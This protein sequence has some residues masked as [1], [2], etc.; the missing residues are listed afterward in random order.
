MQRAGDR[1][2]TDR[3]SLALAEAMGWRLVFLVGDPAYYARYGFAVAPANIVMPDESPSRLQYRTLAGASL[4]PGG[5]ILLRH[6]AAMRHRPSSDLQAQRTLFGHYYVGRRHL[7]AVPG[8]IGRIAHQ[9]YQPPAHPGQCR[10]GPVGARPKS[11]P[12]AV[13]VD[14]QRA[15][16]AGV[17]Y[18]A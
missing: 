9:K 15:E 12:V 1:P 11:L 4:P 18:R 7:E 3:A 14:R 6:A 5:G 17:R 8:V 2:G 16:Q 10:G 13:G